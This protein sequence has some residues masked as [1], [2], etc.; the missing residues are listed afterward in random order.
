MIIN[1]NKTKFMVINGSVENREL[2]A[3]GDL[4]I[5]HCDKYIY[6]G[7][8]F[9]ADASLSTVVKTHVQ[10]KYLILIGL[11]LLLI[12]IMLSHL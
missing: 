8:P 4:T 1:E 7:S 2:I 9:T 10:E 6:L 12:R 11:L 3:V 5:M